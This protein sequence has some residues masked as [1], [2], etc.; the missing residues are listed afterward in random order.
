MKQKRD[1]NK[2]SFDKVILIYCDG[3]TEKCYLKSLKADKYQG[4]RFVIKPGLGASD[5]FEDVFDEI[6]KLLDADE[7]DQYLRIFYLKDMDTVHYQEK[8]EK[9]QKG[10]TKLSRMKH[11]AN[12]L[13]IICSRPCFDFWPLL[14]FDG[15]DR[16]LNSYQ[17]VENELR[18]NKLNGYCKIERYA[19]TLYDKINGYQDKAIKRSKAIC[20]KH[21]EPGEEFSYTLTHRVIE[22]LDSLT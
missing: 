18:S 17:E 12:R 16:L 6:G 5:R 3:I 4:L 21:R 1:K 10:A 2:T 15:R 19:E 8:L 7:A 20:E 22:E 11:A 9:F 14:H 13:Y